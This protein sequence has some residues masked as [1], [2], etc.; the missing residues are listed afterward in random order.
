MFFLSAAPP[1][2]AERA[3]L[4]ARPELLELTWLQWIKRIAS[5]VT[6]DRGPVAPL[7]RWF[8]HLRVV[9][10]TSYRELEVTSQQL[11]LGT[12]LKY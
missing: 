12:Q 11:Q 1:V 8:T 4:E 6:R 10:S 9:I 2:S 7:I 5:T 3:W